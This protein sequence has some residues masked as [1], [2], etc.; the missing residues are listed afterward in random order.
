[1]SVAESLADIGVLAVLLADIGVEFSDRLVEGVGKGET[2]ELALQGVGKFAL[3]LLVRKAL[4]A[5]P[6]RHQ[7]AFDRHHARKVGDDIGFGGVFDE[8]KLRRSAGLDVGGVAVGHFHQRAQHNMGMV[9]DDIASLR[10][11]HQANGGFVPDGID[12]AGL[13]FVRRDVDELAA[14]QD[15]I[16][17]TPLVE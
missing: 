11:Q 3:Q 7:L 15:I 2:A 6:A 1:M 13:P 4:S 17:L 8:C 12:S 9:A 10:D 5:R 14:I 16:S